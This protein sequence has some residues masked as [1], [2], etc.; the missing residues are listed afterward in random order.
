MSISAIIIS[1]IFRD[2]K[3]QHT[4]FAMGNN[5]Q[6]LGSSSTVVDSSAFT[7]VYPIFLL[8]I[9]LAPIISE[10]NPN[11]DSCKSKSY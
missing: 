7:A 6:N 11:G 4:P 2:I 5:L 3:P 8:V 9:A 10:A 1:T